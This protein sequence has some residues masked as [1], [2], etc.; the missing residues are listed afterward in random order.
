MSRV[1]PVREINGA[2]VE[3]GRVAARRRRAV[4]CYVPPLLLAGA[5]FFVAFD[6]G[7]YALTSRN[8]LAIA[9]WWAV[10]L[11][12]A[13]TLW[14][15]DAVPRRAVAAGAFLLGFSILIGFSLLWAEDAERAFNELTRVTL[16]L[17]VFAVAVLAARRGDALRW[18]VGIGGG[19]AALG[20]VALG[21]RLFPQVFPA[22]DIPRFLPAE[23][24]R[25]AYPVDYWNGLATLVA[26]CIPLLLACVASARRLI[27]QAMPLALVP[28]LS[29]TIYLTSSRGGALAA[30]L[31]G[32]VFV[33]LTSGR[34]HAAAALGIAGA[35]S[36]A[37]IAVVLS[38]PAVVDGVESGDIRA[39]GARA[40]AAILLICLVTGAAYAAL[41]RFLPP[42]VRVPRTAMIAVA[43]AAT[44]LLVTALFAVDVRQRFESFKAPPAGSGES[45]VPGHL[46]SASGNGR[47]QWWQAAVDEWESSPI[48]GRG[49]GSYEAWWLEHGTLPV[50]VRDAHSLYLE[51]LGELGFVG[52]L[53]LLG[54]IVAALSGVP[55]LLRSQSGPHRAAT[56]GLVAA[57]VA[58]LVEAGVDWMW[59]LT[60]VSVIAFLFLGLLAGPA[61][62]PRPSVDA[63]SRPR[64]GL[65]ALRAVAVTVSLAA[66]LV[67]AVPLLAQT[68]IEDSQAAVRR[69][70]L[71]GALRLAR[72]ARSIQGWAASPWVQLALVQERVGDLRSAE[73]SIQEAV[74][75]A[76]SDWRVWL[77]ATRIE[78]KLGDIA[79]A[80]RA[81]ARAVELNPR[82]P[83][84]ARP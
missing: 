44:A 75:R 5:V 19:L 11:G 3:R 28:A 71:V 15:L 45:S 33:G 72:Q 82:S 6:S 74:E 59:E 80:R 8:T 46:S 35:G 76:P 79:D 69:G 36:A 50:F 29:S 84:F 17:G 58:Y 9:A 38:Q 55:R 60:A 78:T 27:W 61:T 56:A 4:G 83:L 47:W 54:F 16:Y 37:A 41:V 51:T 1:Q 65:L 63:R 31:G 57:G 24:A 20:L 30:V 42:S 68:R 53:V 32:L 2:E 18:V 81:L 70:D 10:L 21:S 12:V 14:P 67:A 43:A 62:D 77:I 48:I 49:A 26:L 39:Q 52:L 73:F 34:V 25:L 40:A 64:R 66:I 22:S 7:S 23:R 13:L